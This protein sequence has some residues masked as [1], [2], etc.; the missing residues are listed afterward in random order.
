MRA[1]KACFSIAF[2]CQQL[3]VSRSGFYAWCRR[4]E[5]ARSVENR[6][7]LAHIRAAHQIGRGEY[8]SP[9][10]HRELR[11]AGQR[12]G[13]HRVARLM[14]QDGLC[15]R[16]RRR[17]VLTT[18]SEHSHR[19][20]PNALQRQ[21]RPT[22]PN[23]AWAADITYVPTRQGWLYLAVVIDL[24]SRRIVGWHMSTRLDQGLP[25]AAL[26]MAIQTRRPQPGWL[27]HSDRGSQY[28][29]DRYQDRLKRYGAVCSMSRRGNCWDN[30]V[31]ESFFNTL[32]NG[33][34]HDVDFSDREQAKAAVFEYVEVF[35]N[36]QRRHSS[37]DYVSPM[38]YERLAG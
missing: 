29:C 21:F 6:A 36:R 16:R 3:G 14:R 11:A 38:E 18:N 9:R 35:Y 37:L 26:E 20:A 22:G 15:G 33:I 23:R 4:P 8:G 27:H 12:C 1:E 30:A 25:I 17:F 31:V 13:R 19:I 5:P 7:L 32:K 10:I 28:A 24:F 2:M 34:G